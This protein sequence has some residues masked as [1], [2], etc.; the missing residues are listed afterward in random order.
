M[1]K[2]RKKKSTSSKRH[3]KRKSQ[4]KRGRQL[5]A[6]VLAFS[7]MLA[8][9]IGAGLL[10]FSFGRMNGYSMMPEVSDGDV[11]LISKQPPKRFELVYLKTPNKPNERSVRRVIGLPGDELYYQDDQLFVNGQ[12]KSER[13]LNKRK[14]DLLEG[15]LTPD[16]T[17]EELTGKEVVPAGHYFVLGDNR[18]GAT[19][20]RDYQFV[21]QSEIVGVVTT[22]VFPLDAIKTY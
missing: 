17:L 21:K 6:L 16:F 1:A 13:Y 15:V 9:L 4:V 11:L 14:N 7:M 10:T 19:D 8:I 18:Q 2:R 20:S 3:G 22:R 12:G 5:K